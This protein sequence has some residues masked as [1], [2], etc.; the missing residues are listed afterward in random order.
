MLDHLH[1]HR[2]VQARQ[3]LVAIGQRRLEDP[4]P[5]ALLLGHPLQAQP[6][7]GDFQRPRRH[8]DGDDQLDAAFGEQIPGQQ[9][10]TAAEVAHRPCARRTQRGEDRAAP[11]LG[12][13]HGPVRAVQGE[14]ALDR[15]VELLGLGVVD[16]GQP[17]QRR[18]G[19]LPPVGQI[20]AGDELLV[21]MGREPAAARADQLVDLVVADPVVLRV[22][23]HGQQHVQ[24]VERIG[25]PD[26]CGQPDVEV[27]RLA[28]L[29]HGRI[30]L[31]GRG[32]DLPA[33]RL[34]QAAQQVGPAAARHRRH[35]NRRAGWAPAPARG[36]RRTGRSAPCGTHPSAPSPACS[37]PRTGG[38]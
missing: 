10:V 37:T 27:A 1:Q 16:L 26:A 15:V 7:P 17:G 8:V 4:D 19:Q 2:G 28:P 9:A 35:V 33:E 34:E 32:L 22:V 11:L 25:E 24:V 5:A 21:R 36:A 30:E 3:P 13:G 18:G 29:G 38:R 23:Q 12:Q 14:A 20:P 31:P 6:P